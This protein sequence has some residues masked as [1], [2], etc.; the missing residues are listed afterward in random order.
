MTLDQTQEAFRANPTAKA[1]DDYVTEA[2]QYEGDG[3]IGRNELNS[4]LAEVRDFYAK[5]NF[6][7]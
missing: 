4:I 2:R 3:M 1:A 5:F 6:R 7:R